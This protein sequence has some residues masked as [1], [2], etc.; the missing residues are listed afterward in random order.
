MITK[1]E[2]G[3]SI[4]TNTDNKT[5]MYDFLASMLNE[6]LIIFDFELKECLYV[7]NKNNNLTNTQEK[8]VKFS[9]EELKEIIHPEDF[10]LCIDI[11]NCIENCLYNKSMPFDQLNYFSFLLRIKNFFSNKSSSGYFMS[12]IK[13]KPQWINNQMRYGICLLSASIIRKQNRLLTAHYINHDYSSFSFETKKWSYYKFSPLT[14]RQKEM[15]L[16]A[17][18]GLSLKETAEKMNV[19]I[20]TIE[21][22]RSILYEKLGVSSIEQAIQ[23]VS[24]RKLIY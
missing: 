4:I 20:K 21:N 15:L 12:F 16:W 22:M 14:K 6:I 13:L 9:L 7:S 19:S 8:T 1:Q 24:N 3:S 18:Q 23:Y 17:Q 11:Y 5:F 2:V 10:T